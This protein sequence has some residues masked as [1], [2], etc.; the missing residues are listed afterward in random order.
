MRRLVVGF[1][2]FAA[3]SALLAVP[4][5]AADVRAIRGTVVDDAGH[6]VA[7]ASV[8]VAGV[9]A[10]AS[11]ARGAFVLRGLPDGAYTASVEAIGF[12]PIV[13]RF[14]VRGGASA[15]LRVVLS[16]SLLSLRTIGSVVAHTRA[17]FNASPVAVKIF[18]R[19]AYRDQSQPDLGSVLSQTPGALPSFAQSENAAVR[20]V[21]IFA[22]IRG[23]LPFESDTSI[24]G[25]PVSLPSSGA[26]DLATIPS[27]VLQDVEIS[28]GPGNVGGIG[29][30]AIAGS[31]NVRTADPTVTRR[32]LLE[33]GADD[34]GGSFD[35]LWYGGTM[36]GGKIAIAAM[37]ATDGSR[38]PLAGMSFPIAMSGPALIDG[39]P[40]TI[41]STVSS[42]Q[43]VG[44]C[45]AVPSDD[46][47]RAQL[48]T[49]RFTPSEAFSLT[50]TFVGSQT[51]RALAGAEGMLL[52][53]SVDATA[54]KDVFASLAPT[55]AARETGTFALYDL[56]AQIERGE[57]G[58]D[59][60]AYAVDQT[61]NDTFQSAGPVQL[62]LTGTAAYDDGTTQTFD[63][64]SA[65]VALA[66]YPWQ[67]GD[68]E[69]VAGVRLAW[70]HQRGRNLYLGSIE[71]R[72][73]SASGV[74]IAAGTTSNDVL[75]NA[76]TQLHPSAKVELDAG[77][78]YDAHA[79]HTSTSLASPFV[80]RS[81]SAAAMQ[82]AASYTLR[83][84]LA[85]RA[86][87][88]SSFAQPPLEALSSTAPAID[89]HVGLPWQST[90][91]LA[92]PRLQIESA[93]G[94][95]VGL[96]WRLHGNTTTLSADAFLMTTHGAFLPQSNAGAFVCSLQCAVTVWANG[97][98]VRESGIEASLVQ[99]KRVGLGF[100]AQGA[101]LRTYVRGAISPGFYN[102]DTNLGVLGSQNIA[103]GGFFVPGYNDIAATRVP[104]AQGYS[105]I[106]YKWPRGSRL[107]L[108][109]LYEGA[110]NPYATPAM[111]TFN[112]NLELS[113]G[114]KEKLQISV[115]NVFNALDGR[116]PTAF[117]GIGVP[118]ALGTI[119]GTNANV[120]APRTIRFV[121]RQSL[122]AGSVYER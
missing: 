82:A 120:L 106:S 29:P 90:W 116:L 99:F 113:L 76:S 83:D 64:T 91:V 67:R 20:G 97:P 122:G 54:S 102:G 35:D 74:G 52:P 66:G 9:A 98:P 88:G 85:L 38:G 61:R 87:L 16:P 36:P 94:Y 86:A 23:S 42:A 92:N 108:G 77:A 21:P 4:V 62:A 43:L 59:L 70:Q 72:R 121:F 89:P 80:N 63:G 119:A 47:R 8:R 68:V 39:K 17:P 40:A 33:A 112:A 107:S 104:Y 1:T 79:A 115:E 75:A 50:G 109:A 95:D 11:D 49:V 81:W 118:T 26:F 18:P 96:E 117:G 105:E 10:V 2:A 103:G 6:A 7:G 56:D 55:L 73:S 32:V 25:V 101:L 12:E 53:V 48:L 19:E 3:I 111:T 60:R 34:R 58:F 100:I 37:I 22:S 57:D 51:S 114:G 14:T 24:D 93:F 27:F 41:S 78:G 71:L 5:F 65:T 45:V 44:C 28:K 69:R 46:L 30:G 13:L 15:P 110:N 84:G 31:L